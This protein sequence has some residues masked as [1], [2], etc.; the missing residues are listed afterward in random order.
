VSRAQSETSAARIRQK[1]ATGD[2]EAVIARWLDIWRRSTSTAVALK[3]ES[4]ERHY[5]AGVLKGETLVANGWRSRRVRTGNRRATGCVRSLHAPSC[6]RAGGRCEARRRR[7]ERGA[8]LWSN[9]RQA[10]R[11]GVTCFAGAAIRLRARGYELSAP[12]QEQDSCR[13]LTR[14]WL[15]SRA[16]RSEALDSTKSLRI[17]PTCRSCWP[18]GGLSA[19]GRY[20]R[21]SRL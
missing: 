2:I 12:T 10:R 14:H 9:C 4:E 7:Y 1:W 3:T 21:R 18:G 11:T 13:N 19:L 17:G 8:K 15:S 20:E 5:I 6:W 16:G